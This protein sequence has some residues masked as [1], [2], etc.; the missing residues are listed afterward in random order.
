ME[1]VEQKDINKLE[2]D[3]TQLLWTLIYE[4]AESEFTDIRDRVHFS[5][6]II[7]NLFI[8]VIVTFFDETVPLSS[9]KHDIELSLTQLKEGFQ[10]ALN[11][12][13][14]ERAKNKKIIGV[15]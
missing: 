5:R 9:I 8:N 2:A 6:H 15:H 10:F 4:K 11:S 3:F 1:H 13:K 12:I 14:T 7:M